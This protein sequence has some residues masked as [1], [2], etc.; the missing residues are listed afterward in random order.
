M[1]K[2]TNRSVNNFIYVLIFL[3]VIA[4]VYS[5]VNN[6]EKFANHLY[7]EMENPNSESCKGSCGAKST[8]GNC[9]CDN[10]CTNLG[11]CCSDKKEYCNS[12]V[13]NEIAT[14]YKK[15]ISTTT[16]YKPGKL[17]FKVGDLYK[18]L[19]SLEEAVFIN[20][21]IINKLE[22]MLSKPIV[23]Y[24]YTNKP[25]MNYN[26]QHNKTQNSIPNYINNMPNINVNKGYKE[27]K[28]FKGH[29]NT[30]NQI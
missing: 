10:S 9:W 11:D 12:N 27:M 1:A 24:N 14:S 29:T 6:R 8:D 13:E 22:M 20:T 5:L 18:K 16:E 7:T 4:L 17:H 30:Y 25:K 28:Q 2:I 15:P 21:N 23:D 26:T 3:L 19:K